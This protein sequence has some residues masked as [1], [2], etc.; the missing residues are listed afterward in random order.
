M[1]E[2]DG[3]KEKEAWISAK[4]AKLVGEEGKDPKQASAIAYSMW[5]QK[6]KDEC[7]NKKRDSNVDYS[8]WDFTSSFEETPEGYLRGRAIITNV[9][10]F[11]YLNKDG[12]MRRELRLP[13]EV[14]K[15]ES[16]DSIIG[17]PLTNNHPPEFVDT[18][19]VKDYEIGTIMGPINRDAYHVSAGIVVTDKQAISDI[20]MG[21]T[22]LSCGYTLELDWTPGVW[23]GVPYDCIQ[24]NIQINHVALVDKARAGD[25]ARIN[26]DSAAEYNVQMEVDS[27]ADKA[28]R[29][30]NLDNVEYQAEDA[31]IDALKKA[32]ERGDSL[33][34]EVAKLSTEK[35]TIE[36]ERDTLKEKN[37]SLVKEVT[38]LKAKAVDG[39]EI[40][41]R[42]NERIALLS[43]AT[44]AKVEVKDGM[45]AKA[46]KEAVVKAVFPKANLDGK[47]DDYIQARFDHAIEEMDK[48]QNADE[49]A[50]K[51][52]D[53]T[54]GKGG[55]AKPDKIA[56]ARAKMVAQYGKPSQSGK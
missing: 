8:D 27:M 20:K 21:K 25:A 29:T 17:K 2:E 32:Q 7:K 36:A 5:E 14:F 54:A 46:I 1:T 11:S 3:K 50:R 48:E 45:D 56:E 38:E 43:V 35:S 24:R 6:Q 41:K 49:E 18:E 26:L 30:I 53:D 28:F 47:N 16:L 31:V 33:D 10:V 22:A 40:D 37:D 51:L 15:Q 9:G 42:V 39:A 55:A 4:I 13:E 52:N 12:T 19:N 44:K 34:K 23:M